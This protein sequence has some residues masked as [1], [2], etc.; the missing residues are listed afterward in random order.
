MGVMMLRIDVQ[1]QLSLLRTPLCC[2][3]HGASTHQAVGM[4]R[5]TSAGSHDP[6]PTRT[7]RGLA[8]PQV[9]ILLLRRR[10]QS[11]AL[12]GSSVLGRIL[13]ING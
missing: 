1:Q 7:V 9:R 10:R 2:T 5:N 6:F 3:V 13:E 11:A 8:R 12:R 4:P